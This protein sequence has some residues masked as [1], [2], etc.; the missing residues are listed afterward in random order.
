MRAALSDPD[1]VVLVVDRLILFSQ[2]SL[3]G[4]DGSPWHSRVVQNGS[5][6][7]VVTTGR[8]VHLVIEVSKPFSGLVEIID[9]QR[10]SPVNVDLICNSIQKTGKAIL[11]HD[12]VACGGLVS[13]LALAIYDHAYWSLDCPILHVTAPP[14]PVPASELLEDSFM[15]SAQSIRD[16]LEELIAK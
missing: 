11:V 1:P 12:E 16:A 14:T 10:V 5:K 2:N 4:D 13:S 15:V 9:L 6:V 8:L 7:T 3:P